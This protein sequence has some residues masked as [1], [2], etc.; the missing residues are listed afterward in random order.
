M[1]L[2][3]NKL[4]D[5]NLFDTSFSELATF[6]TFFF[7]NIYSLYTKQRIDDFHGNIMFLLKRNYSRK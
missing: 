3:K 7:F 5:I 4:N 1:F 6:P 2:A